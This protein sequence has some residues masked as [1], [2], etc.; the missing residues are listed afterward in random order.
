MR[1][2]VTS[3]AILILNRELTRK[4]VQIRE[5]IVQMSYTPP[6]PMKDTPT[7]IASDSNNAST[8]SVSKVGDIMMMSSS[9]KEGILKK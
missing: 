1:N 3:I 5:T 9:Q 8:M 4:I 6:S 2:A 7:T